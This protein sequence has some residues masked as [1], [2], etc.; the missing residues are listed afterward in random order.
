MSLTLPTKPLA[1]KQQQAASSAKIGE[2]NP[3]KFSH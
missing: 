3:W 1:T 2:E